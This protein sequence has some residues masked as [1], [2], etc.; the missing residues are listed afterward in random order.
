MSKR[1]WDKVT[2]SYLLKID[3]FYNK[4]IND[5]EAFIP[6]ENV[7]FRRIFVE[8]SKNNGSR[9][10]DESIRDAIKGRTKNLIL[11]IKGYAGC[12]KSVYIQK[13]MY[14][15]YPKSN[16]FKWNTYNFK[17]QSIHKLE[18][19]SG[20]SNNDIKS[21][22]IDNISDN[23]AMVINKDPDMFHIFSSIIGNNDDAIKYIDNDLKLHDE[24]I[25]SEAILSCITKEYHT[26]RNALRMELKQYEMPLLFAIDCLWRIAYHSNS[27]SKE[28]KYK[29]SLFFICFD[30]LDAIDNISLC[31][32]F[33]NKLCE[34][35]SN[36]DECLF[37]L[38]KYHKEYNV[39]TFTFILS[40]RN[41][42][43]GR[44]H[45][46][47]YSEDDESGDTFD[48]LRNCA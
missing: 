43:W 45:L 47:E 29:E 42:T 31:R 6:T 41:V 16:N 32:Q 28:N 20:T 17:P 39:K 34:F 35:R 12:G 24:L 48:H 38:N 7:F 23:M 11:C 27:N 33:I 13:L 40:C 3:P 8:P 2:S 19:G 25:R 10:K 21:R 46:S 30:N 26:L 15:F 4:K 44:L 36:L 14:D 37:I 9:K 18:T 5:C 1:N 22:Y